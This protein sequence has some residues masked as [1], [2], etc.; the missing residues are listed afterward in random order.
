MSILLLLWSFLGYALDGNDRL[1]LQLQDGTEV[2]GWYYAVDTESLVLSGENRLTKVPIA[3][4]ESVLRDEEVLSIASFHA[5]VEVV[6]AA[7]RAE[8][9]N[10]PPHPHP[11]LVAGASMLW[12]GAGHALLGE[13]KEARGY[14]IVEGVILGAAAYNVY[15]RSALGV[16]VSLAALDLLFKLYAAEES[17]QLTRVRRARLAAE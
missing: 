11:V 2:R 9:A 1:V 5:E 6:L 17:M 3:A 13:W 12:A 4:I 14:S 16:L 8:R 10:P 7:A 15:R